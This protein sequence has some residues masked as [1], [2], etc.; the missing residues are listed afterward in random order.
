MGLDVPE[1]LSIPVAILANSI[2][3]TIAEV[4]HD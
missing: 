1:T 3:G 2:F 4:F